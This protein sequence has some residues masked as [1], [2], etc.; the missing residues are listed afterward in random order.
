MG[1]LITFAAPGSR[2]PSF[3]PALAKIAT[4][5]CAVISLA[6]MF[7][8]GQHNRSGLLVALFTVWVASPFAALLWARRFAYW[9]TYAAQAMT[10]GLIFLV[11]IGSAV[12]YGFAAFGGHWPKPALPF[13]AAPLLS[14]FLIALVLL[15]IRLSFG[16]RFRRAR[17]ARG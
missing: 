8:V 14:W 7:R 3:L 12:F 5:T 13:L 10:Y 1:N 11:S 17:H 6:C 4:L 9:Y 16:G 2:F 15:V